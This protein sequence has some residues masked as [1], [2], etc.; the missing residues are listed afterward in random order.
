MGTLRAGRD[1]RGLLGD[2]LGELDWGRGRSCPVTCPGL[3]P[4]LPSTSG[5]ALHSGSTGL[6]REAPGQDMGGIPEAQ[7]QAH[8]APVPR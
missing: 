2:L 5:E 8:R 6:P 4:T 7:R 3:Q 1:L